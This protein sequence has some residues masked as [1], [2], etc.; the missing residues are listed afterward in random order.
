MNFQKLS[1]LAGYLALAFFG[2]ALSNVVIGYFT[3]QRHWVLATL[4]FYELL[5]AFC[6]FAFWAVSATIIA[7]RKNRETNKPLK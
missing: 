5:A 2:L 3:M 6:A 4:A 1:R 7:I